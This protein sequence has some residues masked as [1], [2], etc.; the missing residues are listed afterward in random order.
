MGWAEALLVYRAAD[1]F[2]GAALVAQDRTLLKL[3]ATWPFVKVTPPLPPPPGEEVDWNHVWSNTRVDFEG[4]A[5]M[6]QLPPVAV[7]AGF[8]A[9]QRNRLILPDGTLESWERLPKRRVAARLWERIA[10]LR[11]RSTP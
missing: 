6:T 4:W 8:E 5:Q 3:A 10:E 7:L 9:L 11:S 1:N 2:R